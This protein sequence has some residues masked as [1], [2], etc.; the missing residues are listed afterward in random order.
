MSSERDEVIRVGVRLVV[1]GV[2]AGL[3]VLALS[4]TALSQE[5]LGSG[6]PVAGMLASYEPLPPAARI[7]EAEQL[8]RDER[9]ERVARASSAALDLVWSAFRLGEISA[10]P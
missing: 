10:R 3:L 1:V 2:A 5:L 8:L 7:E 6:G 9:R 4:G